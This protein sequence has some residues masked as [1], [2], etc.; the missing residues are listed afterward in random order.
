[1]ERTNR[2][3]PGLAGIDEKQKRI[4][5]GNWE[6]RWN[7]EVETLNVA[8]ER[9]SLSFTLRSKKPPGIHGENGVIQKAAGPRH[10][11]PSISFTRLQTRGTLERAGK[12]IKVCW[13]SG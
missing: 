2:A 13:T 7:G 5:N 1:M 11:S 3:G 10:A 9:F 12:P 8:D 6:I 4:W